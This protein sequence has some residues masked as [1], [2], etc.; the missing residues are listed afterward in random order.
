MD[1]GPPGSHEIVQRSKMWVVNNPG[2]S[3]VLS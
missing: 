3:P 2:I 1:R